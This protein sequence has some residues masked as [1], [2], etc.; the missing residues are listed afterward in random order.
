[1]LVEETDLPKEYWDKKISKISGAT[2]LSFICP[3][4]FE[5]EEDKTVEEALEFH[6]AKIGHIKGLSLFVPAENFWL[7]FVFSKFSKVQSSEPKETTVIGD[8]KISLK[9]EINDQKNK[10]NSCKN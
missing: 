7:V 5:F 2:G 9:M 8:L 1:M 6:K 4:K 3:F 10:S